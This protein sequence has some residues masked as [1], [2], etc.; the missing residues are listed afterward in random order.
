[1]QIGARIVVVPTSMQHAFHHS[2][3]KTVQCGTAQVEPHRHWTQLRDACESHAMPTENFPPI[4]AACSGWCL[5]L[6]HT[7]NAALPF[8]CS[9]PRR[10]ATL[11]SMLVLPSKAR[12]PALAAL[13]Y[14]SC[15]PHPSNTGGCW[16]R[17]GGMHWATAL[18]RPH[19]Q[20]LSVAPW[21]PH[22]AHASDGMRPKTEGRGRG[23]E[24]GR[25]EGGKREGRGHH[26]APDPQNMTW[27][28]LGPPVA[29]SSPD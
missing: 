3:C 16:G 13:G 19:A 18:A 24:G 4:P 17:D 21:R 8:P 2:Q 25:G 20:S 9:L 28:Y 29:K 14:R 27:S 7:T 23:R 15:A 5:L 22:S 11:L 6:P 26:N 10:A 12:L 1:M